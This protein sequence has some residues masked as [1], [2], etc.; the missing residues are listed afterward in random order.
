MNH[1]GSFEVKAR[2]LE[3][4]NEN[5]A[6]ADTNG[7]LNKGAVM[8]SLGQQRGRKIRV[9]TRCGASGWVTPQG[10]CQTCEARRRLAAETPPERDMED[11]SAGKRDFE[12]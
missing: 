9:C 2:E 4:R 10:L 3:N 8:G 5:S 6:G 11:N 1:D 7:T 12:E